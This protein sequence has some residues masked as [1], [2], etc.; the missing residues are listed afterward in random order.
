MDLT[1]LDKTF[2]GNSRITFWAKKKV[3]CPFE[4]VVQPVEEFPLN[5][6]NFRIFAT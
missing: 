6:Y 2:R 1:K 3:L 4:V 5:A